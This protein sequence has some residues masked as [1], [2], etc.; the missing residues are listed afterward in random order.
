M[1]PPST[2]HILTWDLEIAKPVESLPNGWE[3]A[4]SGGAGI[5]CLVIY[6]NQT[7]R[8]H[9]YDSHTL[10]AAVDHLNSADLIVGFNTLGFDTGVVLGVT[11]RHIT[12]RQY[13][14]LHEIWAA[15]GRRLK[16]YKLDDVAQRTIQLGKSGTGEFATALVAAKRWA[17]LFDYCI[18]DVHITRL[19]FN[20]IV[21]HGWVYTPDMDTLF[22]DPPDTEDLA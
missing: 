10:D 5:S 18:G 6:D 19:L 13:D 15:I 20:H 11:N 9:L 16:G 17:E 8:Y 1:A 22:L 12:A 4:R 21:Q 7:Q 2:M 3:D 14:I